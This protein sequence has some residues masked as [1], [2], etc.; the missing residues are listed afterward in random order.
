MHGGVVGGGI[1]VICV[2]T[3]AS[4]GGWHANE[5]SLFKTLIILMM[6]F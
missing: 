2:Q 5:P 6:I 1:H 4:G 3:L